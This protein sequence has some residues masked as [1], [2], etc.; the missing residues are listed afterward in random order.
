MQNAVYETFEYDKT[1]YDLYEEAVYRALRDMLGDDSVDPEHPTE[2]VVF[3][4]ENKKFKL[5]PIHIS[6]C[7]AGRGG[8][9]DAILTAISRLALTGTEEFK[10]TCVEKNKNAF[11]T[12]Q[13]RQKN[14]PKWFSTFVQLSLVCQ[15]MRQWTPPIPIDILVTELL[16]S[17]ADNE[18]SPECIDGVIHHLNPVRGI[19]IPHNY[20]S[21]IEPISAHKLWTR[22]REME[23][24]ESVLV[25][26]LDTIFRPG[27]SSF[28]LFAFD[29][30]RV[31]DTSSLIGDMNRMSRST[32]LSWTME[33]DT[34]IH[35]FAG[36][37]HAD[38]YGGVTMSTNPPTR[39]ET[40]VSWFP[41]FLPLR[42]PIRLISGQTLSV[43]VERKCTQSTMWIEWTVVEPIVQPT[44]NP[45][46]SI[47]SVAI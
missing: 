22:A 10:I 1:K 29:H 28:G 8:L 33:I 34:T 3:D 19:S 36:Y 44:N 45:S 39:T 40:M 7:G 41:A 2:N 4:G 9:V 16:G 26:Q 31:S 23:K 21:A 14:D 32:S 30:Q 6:V 13:F 35:G 37:F 42:Y 46:G 17:L 15:D 12:L 24:F 43:L 18:A 25:A 5:G 38:L 27:G 11:R 20:Y 47:Y